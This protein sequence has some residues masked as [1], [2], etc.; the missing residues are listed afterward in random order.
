MENG[1][2]KEKIDK[3]KRDK[4]LPDESEEAKQDN[5][6]TPTDEDMMKLENARNAL[7]GK[8]RGQERNHRKDVKVWKDNIGAQ[9]A[10]I[11]ELAKIVK[12]KEQENRISRLKI[13]EMKRLVKHNQLKPLTQLRNE[14]I[15]QTF[16]DQTENIKKTDEGQVVIQNISKSPAPKKRDTKLE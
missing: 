13:K 1:V 2:L 10:K 11:E 4:N 6:S 3:V 5:P 14:K 16:E 15:K 8:I 12:E 9:E 7:E